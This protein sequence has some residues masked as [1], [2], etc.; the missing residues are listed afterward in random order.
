MVRALLSDS[1]LKPDWK[2]E[3]KFYPWVPEQPK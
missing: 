1:N 2:P 3:W